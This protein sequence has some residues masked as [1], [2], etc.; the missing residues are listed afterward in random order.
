MTKN[1]T[2]KNFVINL[3]PTAKNKTNDIEQYD[4][5]LKI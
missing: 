3:K 2:T 5:C 4:I 1:K